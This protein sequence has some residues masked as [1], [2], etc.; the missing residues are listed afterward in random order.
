[1][2][3][4]T[5]TAAASQQLAGAPVGAS[6]GRGTDKRDGAGCA[7]MPLTATPNAADLWCGCPLQACSSQPASLP[8]APCCCSRECQ[9]AHWPAHKRE[10]RP[11][12]P[13]APPASAAAPLQCGRPL[14]NQ[15]QWWHQRPGF[16]TACDACGSNAFRIVVQT[17]SVHYVVGPAAC[18]GS[19]SHCRQWHELQGLA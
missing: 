16:S 9:A 2:P 18:P 10:C 5:A 8:A 13:D 11:D 14:K 17:R 12:P 4:Q 15:S 1:M 19:A 7:C 3:Q 6:R